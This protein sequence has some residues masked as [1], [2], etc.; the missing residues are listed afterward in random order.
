MGALGFG[1]AR[2]N[3]R[4]HGLAGMTISQATLKLGGV[5]L[6]PSVRRVENPEVV[7]EVVL[8]H[9]PQGT[10]IDLLCDWRRGGGDLVYQNSWQTRAIDGELWPARCRHV[11]SPNDAAGKWSVA[12]KQGDREL[13]DERFVIE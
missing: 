6:P 3:A 5:P 1:I 10:G 8:A 4:A 12:M 9:P 2:A 13:A 7:F 11:F